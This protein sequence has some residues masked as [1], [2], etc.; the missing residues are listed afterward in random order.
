MA[1]HAKLS[2]SAASRWLNCP[3]SINLCSTVPRKPVSKYATEGSAAHYLGECCLHKAA[4]PVDRLGDFINVKENGRINKVKV[5]ADMV[6]AVQ[7]YVDEVRRVRGELD[8]AE[9]TIESRVP[10]SAWIPGGFGTSDHVAVQPFGKLMIHD[11]KHGA[12]VPVDA[13]GNTQMRIYALGALGPVNEAQVDTV[14]MVIVQ[15]RAPH[16]DGPIRS[17]TMS[18]DDLLAWG[19]DVLKP[20]AKAT[21]D[22]GAPRRPGKW[23]RWCDASGVCP[24]QTAGA[25]QAMFGTPNL[26]ATVEEARTVLPDIAGMP[27]EKLAEVYR[28]SKELVEPWLKAAHVAWQDYLAQHGPAHGYKLVAGRATRKWADP[29]RAELEATDLL[30]QGAYEDPKLK[31]VA[32]IEKTLKS[33]GLD[34]NSLAHLVEVTKGVSIAAETDKRPALPPVP[35]QMFGLPSNEEN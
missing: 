4:Q 32:Q 17:D 23:C 3:G 12:G 15:P 34:P 10:L 30:D 11:Y 26:P 21:Q 8:G 9:F 18:A 20:G 5:T 25:A 24:E 27:P 33:G 2:P 19:H 13:I 1:A 16:P 29:I 14:E 28:I 22:P 6:D 35:E 7:V 31:S